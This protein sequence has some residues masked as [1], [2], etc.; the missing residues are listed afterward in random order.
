M[1]RFGTVAKTMTRGSAPV[2]LTECQAPGG[3]Y[4]TDPVRIETSSNSPPSRRLDRAFAG[5][6][7]G[8]LFASLVSMFGQVTTGA[9][10]EPGE[11]RRGIRVVAGST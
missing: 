11:A 2:F 8:E 3:M 6:Q 9:Q 7:V 10:R 4:Q 5:D 1:A